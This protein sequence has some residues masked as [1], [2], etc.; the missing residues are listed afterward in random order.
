MQFIAFIVNLNRSRLE[1]RQ[2]YHSGI[3]PDHSGQLSLA[4][5]PWIGAMST[6][7]GFRNTG[8]E[9]GSSA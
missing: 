6:G 3:Y 8:K 2:V 9:T 1:I 5:P 4:I 7:D